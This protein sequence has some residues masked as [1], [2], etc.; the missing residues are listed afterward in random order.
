VDWIRDASYQDNETANFYKT[1][2]GLLES[3]ALFNPHAGFR[4]CCDG[5]TEDIATPIVNTFQKW[6][7]SDPT[8]PHWYDVETLSNLIG[9]HLTNG[10]G[11][12]T[13]REFVSEFAGLTSPPKQKGVVATAGLERQRLSDLVVSD[14]TAIDS[15]AVERL[16]TA[17]SA[18]SK[19]VK[20]SKLGVIGEEALTRRLIEIEGV[21]P[22]S[23]RYARALNEGAEPAV[24]EVIWGIREAPGHV[25][26]DS[27]DEDV[28]YAR[29]EGRRLR[30][31]LN[32]APSV[33]NRCPIAAVHDAL[34]SQMVE[35]DD[36]VCMVLHAVAPHI[37]FA[38]KGK[39][40]ITGGED[41]Y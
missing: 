24:M 11:Q 29:S 39:S 25:P 20:A 22:E 5:K 17:M 15:A 21:N 7:P 12:K 34:H 2:R 13:V 37:R 32:F 36:P 4:L 30:Y 14:G 10:N 27:E 26:I 16:L 33:G 35:S 23:I 40:M 41:E 18:E 9:A 3:Y 19:T 31:G 28:Y 8:P 6:Q 1:I 38:D